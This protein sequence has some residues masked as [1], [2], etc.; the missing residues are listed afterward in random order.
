MCYE[1]KCSTCGK[2][3]WGGC[4][5]HVPSVYKRIPE[6]Q[7]CQCKNWPGVNDGGSSATG[8]GD[9]RSGCTIL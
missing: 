6:G 9:S 8:D 4:G 3:S 1:T 5:R 7:H 2:T